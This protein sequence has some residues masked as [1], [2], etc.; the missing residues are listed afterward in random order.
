MASIRFILIC[1]HLHL[2][3][4]NGFFP[5][6]GIKTDL[7]TWHGICVRACVYVDYINLAHG[8]NKGRAVVKTVMGIGV[9]Y[10]PGKFLAS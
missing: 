5:S 4:L 3:L 1:S 6:D 9:P 10:N 7:Q 8:R 2:S